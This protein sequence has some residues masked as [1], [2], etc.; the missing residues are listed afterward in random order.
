[1]VFQALLEFPVRHT[2][3]PAYAPAQA[4][5]CAH[6]WDDAPQRPETPDL[7]NLIPFFLQFRS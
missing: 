5:P 6:I 1:M 4:R 2:P 7:P 3:L